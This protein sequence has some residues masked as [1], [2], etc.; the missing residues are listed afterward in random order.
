MRKF[1]I[2][3]DTGSDD[4][5]ALVMALRE[6]GIRV[7]AI[8]TVAG[9]VSLED[10]L[11]NAAA[12]VA[13]A[14]SQR[15]PIHRGAAKPLL[16]ERFRAE[17]VH[18]QG[19]M[20]GMDIAEPDRDPESLP[21][22]LAIVE[23]AR[24]LGGE[25]ELLTLGPLTNLAL[26]LSLAPEIAGLFRSVTFMAG[27]GLGSGNVSA[28]AEFNVFCDAEAAAIVLGADWKLRPA[29]VG[30]DACLGEAIFGEADVQALLDSGDGA[31]LF[32]ERCT[33]SVRAFYRSRFALEGFG[34][35]DPAAAAAAFRPELRA[36]VMPARA[37]VETGSRDNYGLVALD[38][39]P[40]V[41]PNVDA[42]LRLHPAAYRAYVVGLLCGK[43]G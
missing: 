31:A 29:L 35:A 3:T 39:R 24:R 34:L 36:E 2:D 32:C 15:P 41:A 33:R 22:A 21:A 40:G 38:R 18:G 23:L 14:G 17:N 20:S 30:W 1:L 12:S 28:L 42:V 25:L 5:V 13:A 26:A 9:N 6:P 11:H 10:A 16:R 19:G 43:G 27:A 8:T 37:T 7:E 4:A